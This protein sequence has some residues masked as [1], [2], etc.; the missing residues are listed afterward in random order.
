MEDLEHLMVEAVLKVLQGFGKG[1]I[2]EGKKD[3]VEG[4]PAF[5]SFLHFVQEEQVRSGEGNEGVVGVAVD[6][7]QKGV[8]EGLSL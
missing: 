6:V 3:L 2:F 8:E 4:E 5:N 1:D 7:V